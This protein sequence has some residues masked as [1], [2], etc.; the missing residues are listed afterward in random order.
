MELRSVDP[1]SLKE[2]PDNPRKIA[3]DAVSD[4][5]LAASI[6]AIGILQPPVVRQDGDDL[7]IIAGARRIRAAIALDIK[8]II[9]LVRAPDAGD[10]MRSLSENVVRAP[11]SNVDLWRAI[12]ALASDHWTEEAVA[13][14]LAV[15][16]RQ[17]KKLR[18][19]ANVHPAMLDQI[20]LGDMP[21]E[22]Y[23]R[24]IACAGAEEQSS[25]WKKHKPKKGHAA[26]WY[27]IARALEKRRLYATAAKFGPDEEQAF[28]IV[29]RED[30]FA[31]GDEDQRY[32]TDVEAF[33]AAQQAW[34]EANLP[35]NGVTLELD[36]YGGPKLPPK[37]ERIWTKPK[38]GDQIGF[39][40]STR[41]GAIQEIAFRPAKP[42][43]KKAGKD[44]E[45][46]H[47]DEFAPPARK[48]RPEITQKG[49]AIIGDLRSEALDKALAEN[50]IDDA[51][52][53]GLLI[54][55]LTAQ[56]V[57]IRTGD[58]SS[59]D[60]TKIAQQITQGGRLTQDLDALRQAAREMLASFLSCRPG[61]NDSGLPARIAGDA[62]GADLHLASMA[63]EE[64][65]SCLSKPAIETAA[66][67]LGVLP[68]PRA[69][70]TRAELIKAAAGGSF[71]LPAA[72]FALSAD[73]VARLSEPPRS[74]SWDEGGED[75]TPSDGARCDS[76]ETGS[77]DVE[78]PG[79][80]AQDSQDNPS[81]IEDFDP[82]EDFDENAHFADGEDDDLRAPVDHL[83]GVRSGAAG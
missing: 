30:L 17:I 37:A 77:A 5:A 15:P 10:G 43:P 73:E 36:Q 83:Y 34:L 29:W 50:A 69:K 45:A 58:Y 67:S 60:R 79:A 28:G 21:D 70:D 42:D 3:P 65:L 64:F 26:V 80:E 38:K 82:D 52:L 7:E 78:D 18:L 20:G 13:T 49:V 14:A 59:S 12:E 66:S 39:A 44:G 54:L 2:N 75:E 9:V 16:V 27:E 1:R 57:S 19:L 47:D 6:K 53:I 4:Q 63:S 40:V 55:S 61:M 31:Q 46:A 74:F 62:I 68:R 51:T 8:E 72:S 56:N 81:G 32:T 33:F 71:V 24:T 25:V 41:D 22:R 76:D 35:K 48:A 11:M 23:L